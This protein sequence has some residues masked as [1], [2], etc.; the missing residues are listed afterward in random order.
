MPKFN[1]NP[2]KDYYFLQP[3]IRVACTRYGLKYYRR[4]GI[5]TYNR[6]QVFWK[7]GRFIWLHRYRAERAL[8]RKLRAGEEVH[9]IDGNHLNNVRTN[10]LICTTEYHKM[11][12]KK[13]KECRENAI[14]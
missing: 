12:H 2:T 8:G 3:S 7:Y 5:L 9:H 1:A 6:Y 4:R 11:L 14:H 13:I 10:L